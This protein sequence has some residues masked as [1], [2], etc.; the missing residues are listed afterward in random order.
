MSALKYWLWLSNLPGIPCHSLVMLTSEMGNPENIYFA[1]EDSLKSIQG[2]PPETLVALSDKS[3]E[4][5]ERIL[6][7]CDKLGIQ[8]LTMQDASYPERLRNIY[9][10]PCVLYYKGTLPSMDEEAALAIVGTRNPSAY[11]EKAASGLAYELSKAGML[12]VSGLAQG[13]DGAAHRGALRAGKPTVAV[14]GSGVERVYPAI[15]RS[16]YED[17]ASAGAVLSEYPPGTPIAP[18]NFPRRNRLMS[19]LSAGVMI[20]EAPAKSGSLITA[21]HAL[22]QG[23]DVFAVPGNIDTPE[24]VG[25]NTLIR[26][27]AILVGRSHDVLTEYQDK[28]SHKINLDPVTL[29][30]NMPKQEKPKKVGQGKKINEQGHKEKS[31]TQ[32]IDLTERLSEYEPEQQRILYAISKAPLIADKI[33]AATGLSASLVLSELTLLE[34]EGIVKCLPGNRFALSFENE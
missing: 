5:S 4:R 25:A 2:L 13:I 31:D 19:G 27:G 34:I 8:M 23:R 29:P 12:I 33:I 17:I 11:G 32:V 9:D 21:R 22:E 24:S 10:P 3:M 15:H 26:E 14:L 28:F 18:A 7:N 1:Q 30:S 16:L 20:I 6:E